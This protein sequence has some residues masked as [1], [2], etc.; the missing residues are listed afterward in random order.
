MSY[1]GESD[2]FERIW[3]WLV[4]D[5]TCWVSIGGVSR[6]ILEDLGN[7]ACLSVATGQS[8]CPRNVVNL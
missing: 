7:V 8:D 1:P 3:G 2:L 4:G 6:L 5:G